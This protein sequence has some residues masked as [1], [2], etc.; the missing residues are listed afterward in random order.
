MRKLKLLLVDDHAVVRA[1]YR[2][3]LEQQ[4][5]VQIVAEA[6]SAE[7]GY[8]SFCDSL[9]DVS[10][11]DLSM[12]G[13]GGLEL[14][15][16]ILSRDPDANILVFSMHEDAQFALRSMEAG[17]RGYVTKSCPPNVIVDAVRQVA[18]KKIYLS[19]DVMQLIAL[20]R[21]TQQSEPLDALSQ[22]EFEIFRLLAE[23]QGLAEISRALCISQKSVANYQTQIKQKLGAN[24]ATELVHIALRHGVITFPQ[25]PA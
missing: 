5:D 4:G 17:A 13:A 25:S 15:R 20:R 8:Q 12:K 14:I 21:V 1:G 9:P 22:R 6:D 16:R 23:G 2:R 19:P 7:R 18:Q 11:I 3:F 24:S 10:V